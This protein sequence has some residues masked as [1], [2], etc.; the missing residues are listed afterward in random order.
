M[1]EAF[2][3]GPA[4]H[5]KTRQA[6]RALLGTDPLDELERI[7]VSRPL[8]LGRERQVGQARRRDRVRTPPRCPAPYD[9]RLRSPPDRRA[10]G[11]LRRRD[12]GVRR[13]ALAGHRRL[14]RDHLAACVLVV[15]ARPAEE[16]D[17]PRDDLDRRA[18][19]AFLL[20]RARLQPAVDG[21]AAALAEVLGAELRLAIPRADVHEV[22][23]AVL[24]RAVDGEEEARHLLVGAD[25]AEVD[26]GREVPD[27]RDDVHGV[28]RR[29]ANRHDGLK[30]SC[31]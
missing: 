13:K 1:A 19:F 8:P 10:S 11:G 4:F 31:R 2:F 28:H 25:L 14:E 23:A 24:A 3:T 5:T 26:V 18:P 22:G 27:Q 12:R 16:L 29:A 21:D 17:P 15:G 20:P 6:G 7:D 30:G 9:R